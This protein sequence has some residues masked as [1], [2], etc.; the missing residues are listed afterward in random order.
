MTWG[1]R[2]RVNMLRR[3]AVLSLPAGRV[4]SSPASTLCRHGRTGWRWSHNLD[5]R[6]LTA[7]PTPHLRSQ[8]RREPH[9]AR[10][11]RLTARWAIRRLPN[12]AGRVSPPT[13]PETSTSRTVNLRLRRPASPSGGSTCRSG[14]CKSFFG[15]ADRR[16][17]FIHASRA[18]Q[19]DDPRAGRAGAVGEV[20]RAA[21][22]FRRGGLPAVLV[23]RQAAGCRLPV[24]VL[25]SAR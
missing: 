18:L 4:F 14:R 11:C 8:R 1:R 10:S 17:L 9:P 2:H 21:G 16:T 12:A 22:V 5:L 25:L 13:A 15:G 24:R 19:R 3:T 7:A 20:T 6:L 23:V